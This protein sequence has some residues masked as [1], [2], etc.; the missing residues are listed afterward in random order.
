[1]LQ[2]KHLT[3]TIKFTVTMSGKEEST[4]V[5]ELIQ[6]SWKQQVFVLSKLIHWEASYVVWCFET[7]FVQ[8]KHEDKRDSA[9][10]LHLFRVITELLWNQ[11]GKIYNIHI[12]NILSNNGNE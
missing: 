12:C 2:Q 1:M 11:H 5:T 6:I 10:T 8:V 3:S 9:C 7:T 4:D